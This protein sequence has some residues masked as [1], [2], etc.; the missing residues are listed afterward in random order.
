MRTGPTSIACWR[1]FWPRALVALLAKPVSGEGSTYATFSALAEPERFGV[2]EE[3]R[4]LTLGEIQP[5]D[6]FRV[7]V[8]ECLTGGLL[9]VL[10][11]TLG[12]FFTWGLLGQPAGFDWY[13]WV[14]CLM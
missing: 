1:G 10:L 12:V 5:R 9:G 6:L 4:G 14:A 11:G 8:R 3:I 7:L 2:L 13:G